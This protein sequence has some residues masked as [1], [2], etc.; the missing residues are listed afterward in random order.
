MIASVKRVVYPKRL[1]Q[2]F[3]VESRGDMVLVAY[4]EDG[5]S[6][7]KKKFF[8]ISETAIF[9][10]HGFLAITGFPKGCYS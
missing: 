10:E 4:N 2:G 7:K 1:S 5:D 9:P 3:S 8:Q 6:K